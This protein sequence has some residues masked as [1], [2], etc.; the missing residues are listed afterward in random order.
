MHSHAVLNEDKIS[1]TGLSLF[2]ASLLFSIKLNVYFE[3][4]TIS[5]YHRFHTD[6]VSF[7]LNSLIY[8]HE[9]YLCGV[10]WALIQ[11][12]LNFI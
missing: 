2:K 9:H 7:I 4:K 5:L 11:Q 10:G 8:F 12:T 3:I 6:F 1:F